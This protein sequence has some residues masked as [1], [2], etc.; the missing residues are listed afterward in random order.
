MTVRQESGLDALPYGP[1]DP[2][3]HR[4]FE[5]GVRD[6]VERQTG[7]RLDYVEQLYTFGDRGREA[8]SASL[9][10]GAAE[11]R[12]VSVG[13]LALV[14]EGGDISAAGAAWRDW[15]GFF[16]WE[17]WRGDEPSTISDRIFP[18]LAAWRD[19]AD[20]SA[21]KTGRNRRIAVAFGLD[22][23][24]WREER[25][26]DRYELMYE[27]GLAPEAFRDREAAG[28]P[29]PRAEPQPALVTGAQMTSDHRRILAT[30]MSRLR[31]KLKYRPII[32]DACAERFTLSELQRAAEAI[33]GFRMHKPNFRRMARGSGLVVDT[34]ETREQ[35]GGRPAAVFKAETTARGAARP[36]LGL[37][38]PRMGAEPTI[39]GVKFS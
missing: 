14:R 25:V 29:A 35:T 10:G 33:C 18:A 20:T 21:E 9:A 13:Y 31:G 38:I 28:L 26:L 34:G 7:L 27:A 15:Y 2:V 12:V 37:A 1:F 24:G 8:P 17:D 4:T 39:K 16:P 36:A 11:D 32:F 22:G 23:G 3:G 19:R 6:F 5:L 30:A